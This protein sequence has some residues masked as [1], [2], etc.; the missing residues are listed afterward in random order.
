MGKR[1][2]GTCHL[3]VIT[4]VWPRSEE[5]LVGH[6]N[7]KPTAEPLWLAGDVLHSHHPSQTGD[8]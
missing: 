2:S 5:R 3:A 6:M 4:A 1:K 7:N 8:H